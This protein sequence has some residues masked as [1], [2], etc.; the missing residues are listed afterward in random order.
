[1]TPDP[2][3]FPDPERFATYI[4]SRSPNFKTHKDLGKAK[5]AISQKADHRSIRRMRCDAWVYEFDFEA[6]M[7]RELTH[8]PTGTDLA[9]HPWYSQKQSSKPTNIGPSEAAEKAAIASIM[10]VTPND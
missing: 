5:N 9:L 10:G 7:W 2:T 6:G 4:A 1:M 3:R 8:I